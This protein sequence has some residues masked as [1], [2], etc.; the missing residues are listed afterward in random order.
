MVA[1][2]T[3]EQI[4]AGTRHAWG[5]H[6]PEGW[7]ARM[8]NFFHVSLL[9]CIGTSTAGIVQDD[10]HWVIKLA[11]TTNGQGWPFCYTDVSGTCG[12]ACRNAMI[13]DYDNSQ[14]F[15]SNKVW[16]SGGYGGLWRYA[17]SINSGVCMAN[18]GAVGADGGL[19]AATLQNLNTHA[20]HRVN[21]VWDTEGKHKM[22][23]NC[24]FWPVMAGITTL[25]DDINVRRGHMSS[26]FR[27]AYALNGNGFTCTCYV[28]R[29]KTD[30]KTEVDGLALNHDDSP[31]K[32][33]SR[34]FVQNNGHLL[35]EVA[36]D[37]DADV[38]N[39][40]DDECN[41]KDVKTCTDDKCTKGLKS[42]VEE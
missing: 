22:C 7:C 15:W 8:M 25:F 21:N 12:A 33:F 18:E 42:A 30:A 29:P 40:C 11:G 31:C 38:S 35:L 20:A 13:A 39:T 4:L 24:L 17:F 2:G 36:T 37:A 19:F 9:S 34:C 32:R 27:A 1:D 28:A 16:G 41:T 26:W 5:Y 3:I 6:P 14:K 23:A 10:S